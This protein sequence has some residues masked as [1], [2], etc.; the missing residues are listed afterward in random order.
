MKALKK[1][2]KQR[3]RR[4]LRVRNRLRRTARGKPRLCVYRS[5]NHMYAQIIDD[6]NGTT[7][8]AANSLQADDYGAGKYAGNKQAAEQVGKLVA[9][10]ALEKG[11][12]EVVFDRGEYK[13]HGR[14]A[15]LAE[16]ARK[17]GLNF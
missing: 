15:A 5:N 9:E 4:L 13:Y 7:L 2:Q 16:A 3:R 1:L 6:V 11:V 12:Q 14:V 17:A 10:R 8:V